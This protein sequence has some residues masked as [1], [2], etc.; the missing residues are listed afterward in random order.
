M[1]SVLAL[2]LAPTNAMAVAQEGQR[3]PR[4]TICRIE[5][6]KLW[7]ISGTIPTAVPVLSV[8]PEWIEEFRPDID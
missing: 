8:R 6:W 2:L 4:G 3:C 1:V 7:N 5:K